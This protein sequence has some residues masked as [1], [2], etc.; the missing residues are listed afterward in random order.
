[1]NV[2]DPGSQLMRWRIQVAE[3]YYEFFHKTGFQNP[4]AD[5]LSR[6]GSVGALEEQKEIPV[7]KVRK[8]ILYEFH[9][10]PVGGKRGM[11][12]TYR[13]ISSQ[14]TWPKM[15]RE[16][17]DYVKQCKSCQVNKILTPKHR[18]PMQ[19]YDGRASFSEVLP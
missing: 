8:K 11:N 1:M 19:A 13:A 15:R 14:Y 9:G 16:V 7:D 2:K 10:S 5:A 18:P 3:Y 4:N 6:V 12:K 17:E